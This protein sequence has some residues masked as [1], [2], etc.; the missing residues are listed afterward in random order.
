[1]N[2]YAVKEAYGY[3]GP[4]YLSS[5]Q[6]VGLRL[7][8]TVRDLRFAWEETPQQMLDSQ[9]QKVRDSAH[10]A[11]IAWAQQSGEG[12]NYTDNLPLQCLHPV[13][14]WYEVPNLFRNGVLRSMLEAQPQSAIPD[15]SQRRHGGR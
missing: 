5:G 6:S 14:H 4:L 13:G 2:F 8:P 11:L 15:G 7:I 10:A 1:M 3:A 12:S 9:A